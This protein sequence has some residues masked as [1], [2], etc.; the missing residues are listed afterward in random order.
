MKVL[1]MGVAINHTVVCMMKLNPKRYKVMAEY[2]NR[3]KIMHF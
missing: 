2:L 3:E 1:E